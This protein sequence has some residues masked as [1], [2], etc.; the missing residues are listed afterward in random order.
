MIEFRE[1]S[2]FTFQWEN[3]K[4]KQTHHIDLV[5]I[6][7]FF[8]FDSIIRVC[9]LMKLLTRQHHCQREAY[10]KEKRWRMDVYVNNNCIHWFVIMHL[11]LLFFHFLSYFIR[12]M[13]L[14][15]HTSVM[16]ILLIVYYDWL[17]VIECVSVTIFT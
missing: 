9:G 5:T 17:D 8:L 1:K 6:T 10:F 4:M 11:F 13:L 14:Y 3:M 7:F 16:E 12:S 15:V 2:L